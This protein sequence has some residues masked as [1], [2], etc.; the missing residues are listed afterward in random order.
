MATEFELLKW[1]FE[2]G[3]RD[4]VPVNQIRIWL[5]GFD[6]IKSISVEYAQRNSVWRS[7][8]KIWL[9]C[10]MN[11]G[12]E[13]EFE[14]I[15]RIWAWIG[16]FDSNFQRIVS[17][18]TGWQRCNRPK[19]KKTYGPP[20]V[21]LIYLTKSFDRKSHMTRM[22]RTILRKSSFSFSTVVTNR[23]TIILK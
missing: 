20:K 9:K 6:A 23:S 13:L 5:I 18:E 22:Q 17:L 4:P 11:L 19:K 7:T 21:L 12:I 10:W 8:L 1:T 2:F 15:G 14:M 3:L 16:S